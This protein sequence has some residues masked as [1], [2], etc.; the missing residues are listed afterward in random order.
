MHGLIRE[1]LE[2]YLR[3]SGGNKVS[4]EFEEHL[5]SCDECRAEL[6]LMQEQARTLRVLQAERQMDPAPGFYARVIERIEALETPSIWS[7]F[8]QPSFG[9]RI[10]ATSLAMAALLGGYLAF[11]ENQQHGMAADA[12]S[13]IAV[14][15]HPPGLG[16]DRQRDRDTMLV[17][18][19]T[20]QE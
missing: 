1:R 16:Q 19:A 18:L 7:V 12:E 17:T 2:D 4:F 13:I 5:R 3:S 15:Q 10:M 11:T 14:E 20:Y 6:S 8:L 9:R